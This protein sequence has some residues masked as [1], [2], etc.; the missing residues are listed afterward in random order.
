MG[1]LGKVK[2]DDDLSGAMGKPFVFDAKNIDK[3]AKIY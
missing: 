1:K 3:F 2:L